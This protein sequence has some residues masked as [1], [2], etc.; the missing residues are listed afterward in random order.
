MLR[1][2]LSRRCSQSRPLLCFPMCS[3]R[4]R[5]HAKYTHRLTWHCHSTR[6]NS[7]TAAGD[8]SINDLEPFPSERHYSCEAINTCIYLQ[9]CRKSVSVWASTCG[10]SGISIEMVLLWV[11]H[12]SI[13]T[14][15]CFLPL[16]HLTHVY[17][18]SYLK[19]DIGL[20]T[21]SFPADVRVPGIEHGCGTHDLQICYNTDCS[22]CFWDTVSSLHSSPTSSLHSVL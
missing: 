8:A 3:W 17:T 2:F 6:T 5:C 20:L 22:S 13:S 12:R 14:L 18:S 1:C 9:S 21:L 11:V 10:G 7:D 15:I 4:W 16:S 19:I